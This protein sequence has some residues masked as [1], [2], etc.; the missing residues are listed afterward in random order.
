MPEEHEGAT[1][2]YGEQLHQMAELLHR[3]EEDDTHID[4]SKHLWV[5]RVS[6]QCVTCGK[7][8]EAEEIE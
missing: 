2:R 1:E 4:G 6:W 5:V 8:V 3:S 7:M